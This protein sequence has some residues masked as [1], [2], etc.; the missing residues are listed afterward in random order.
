[1]LENEVVGP[2]RGMATSPALI[3]VAGKL[4]ARWRSGVV[5]RRWERAV[6]DRSCGGLKGKGEEAAGRRSFIFF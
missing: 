5:K 1:M 4:A 3:G 6:A 2:S